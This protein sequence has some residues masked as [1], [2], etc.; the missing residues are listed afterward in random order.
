MKKILLLVAS[1]AM[2]AV[3]FTGPAAADDAQAWCETG[4]IVHEKPGVSTNPIFVET[5]KYEPYTTCVQDP[6][7]VIHPV[8]ICTHKPEICV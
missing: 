6:P 5:G 1:A 7:I 3:P 4:V 8:G 2:L